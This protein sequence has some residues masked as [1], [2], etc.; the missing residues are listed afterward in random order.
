MIKTSQ[1]KC[2]NCGC[3]DLIRTDEKNTYECFDCNTIFTVELFD[4]IS[5]IDALDKRLTKVVNP[6]PGPSKDLNS[7]YAEPDDTLTYIGDDE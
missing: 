7:Q 2:P 1:K 6:I 5:R 3:T 4:V